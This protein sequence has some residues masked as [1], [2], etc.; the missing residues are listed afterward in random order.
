MNYRRKAYPVMAFQHDGSAQSAQQLA[1]WVQ[2]KNESAWFPE[3]LP[4]TDYQVHVVDD[5]GSSVVKAG[6]WLVFTDAESDR[7][8]A[9]SAEQFAANF[10][11]VESA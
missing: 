8:S 11:A 6:D 7:F 1:A 5:A 10:E 3:P 4:G 9:C 2:S